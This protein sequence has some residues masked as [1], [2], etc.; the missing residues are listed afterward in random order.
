LSKNKNYKKGKQDDKEIAIKIK[1]G[2]IFK[3]LQIPQNYYL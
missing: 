3:C 1:N 2:R